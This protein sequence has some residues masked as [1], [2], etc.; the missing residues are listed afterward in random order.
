MF[1]LSK[2][3][4]GERVRAQHVAQSSVR[5]RV[6]FAHAHQSKSSRKADQNIPVHREEI[7]E[8]ITRAEAERER[9]RTRSFILDNAL[10]YGGSRECCCTSSCRMTVDGLMRLVGQRAL[11]AELEY[12]ELERQARSSPS[13]SRRR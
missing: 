4:V 13:G 11:L 1:G 2:P 7:V 3:H 6:H 10:R 12:P 9:Y 8:C 5:V